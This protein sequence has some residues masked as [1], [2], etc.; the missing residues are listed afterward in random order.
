MLGFGVL[1]KETSTWGSNRRSSGS[2]GCAWRAPFDGV[3]LHSDFGHESDS[4][5]WG[6]IF[7]PTPLRAIISFLVEFM[8]RSNDCIFYLPLAGWTQFPLGRSTPRPNVW[9]TAILRLTAAASATLHWAGRPRVCQGV[10]CHP[11]HLSYFGVFLSM[12]TRREYFQ[13]HLLLLGLYTSHQTDSRQ[14]NLQGGIHP[15][16]PAACW[17]DAPV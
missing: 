9:C 4:T 8:I 14:Y 16:P 15:H 2:P 11:W 1:P 3:V 12:S 13:M 7:Q 10:P 5:I 17:T 6:F